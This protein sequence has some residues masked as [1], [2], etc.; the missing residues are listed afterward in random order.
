MTLPWTSE[1]K[2][3]ANNSFVPQH[4]PH[5]PL[6][7]SRRC[8][9]RDAEEVSEQKVGVSLSTFVSITLKEL[10]DGTPPSLSLCSR[11]SN[12]HIVHG[13]T[14]NCCSVCLRDYTCLAESGPYLAHDRRIAFTRPC[15]VLYTNK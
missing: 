9:R 12:N 1:S 10:Y 7:L 8:L 13:H 3:G 11:I 6:L 2:K 5:A 14:T 15:G 4:V